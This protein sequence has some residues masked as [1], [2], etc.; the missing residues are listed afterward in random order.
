MTLFQK[1]INSDL[2]VS[3]EYVKV[4]YACNF[5]IESIIHDISNQKFGTV[6]QAAKSIEENVRKGKNMTTA[7][8]TEKNRWKNKNMISFLSVLASS[9]ARDVTNQLTY[10]TNHIIAEKKLNVDNFLEDLGRKLNV[11]IILM[12]VPLIAFFLIE[13]SG[14]VIRDFIPS[15]TPDM[16][17]KVY[18]GALALS[19][20][21]TLVTLITLRYKE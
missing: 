3:I 13:M 9:S 16:A 19:I 6:T 21:G 8:L 20:L 14:D 5:A 12:I 7:I 2:L 17:Q 11:F 1:N 18:L 4:L 10:I 15:L